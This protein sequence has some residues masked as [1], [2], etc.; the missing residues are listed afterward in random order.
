MFYFY[1]KRPGS[2]QRSHCTR[3]PTRKQYIAEG[4]ITDMNLYLAHR[5]LTIGHT[6]YKIS[7][8]VYQVLESFII[9]PI[10]VHAVAYSTVERT[11]SLLYSNNGMVA[12][13]QLSPARFLPHHRHPQERRSLVLYIVQGQGLQ[14][15]RV[16]CQR[17]R[18]LDESNGDTQLS[19][20]RSI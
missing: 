14:L 17:M 5:G 20:G 6:V 3:K 15:D 2:L 18:R 12:A 13:C 9:C 10:T 7:T 11:T 1:A 8:G 4:L 19:G 16:W